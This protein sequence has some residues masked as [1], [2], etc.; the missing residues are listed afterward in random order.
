MDIAV[1]ILVLFVALLVIFLL[2][3][4]SP[5]PSPD[6]SQAMMIMQQQVE[7]LR[8]DV[9]SSLQNIVEN[10]N[11]QLTMV[12][13]QIQSQTS[14]VGNRLDNAAR[15]IGDVQKNLGELGKATQEIKELGQSVSKLEELL[16]A[17]KL[18][19]GLGELLL[20]DLL[21]QVLP[22]DHFEMQYR[23]RNGQIVD[24][25]IRT[26]DRIV[27]IDSKFPLENFRKMAGADN[28]QN[29]KSFQKAFIN[30]VKKHIDAIATKYIL[31]DEGTFPFALMY[32]P[33]ENIYYEVIIK[34]ESTNGIGFYSYALERKVVPV[35]PNS[36]Y[37]YLQVI[38][39]GLRGLQ[40]EHS[41][42]EILNTLSRLQ[43]EITRV[44]EAFDTLGAHLENAH[45]K[46]EEAD[47]RLSNF[48]NRLENVTERSL[49]E[50]QSAQPAV[51]E[52]FLKQ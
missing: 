31:T 32:I 30:D 52:K 36:F 24:A 17:P 14:N 9:R 2:K 23:F 13:Q 20:E 11:Q 5:Q 46:Y 1:I 12:T 21:K 4:Q 47:K 41:A 49:P 35:S 43:G 27:P 48:E 45:K 51:E 3:R 22:A 7:S 44:R 34:D 15:V 50:G 8:G 28:D 6:T 37:A 16:R 10:I 26:S 25:I 40:I 29:K 38:A 33:A 19:G 42:K 18:R 39:L